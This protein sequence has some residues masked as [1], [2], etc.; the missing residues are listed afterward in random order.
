MAIGVFIGGEMSAPELFDA[1]LSGEDMKTLKNEQTPSNKACQCR[2]SDEKLPPTR[3]SSKDLLGQKV[4]V[5]IDT[6]KRDFDTP[7]TII[8]RSV[9]RPN[10]STLLSKASTFA[11]STS[12]PPS[13]GGPGGKR[14]LPE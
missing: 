9:F 14:E 13:E 5:C 4:N 6:G 11:R 8:D 2:N 1:R 10:S 12:S 3:E 7:E